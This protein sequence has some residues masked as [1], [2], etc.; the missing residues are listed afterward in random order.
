[1]SKGHGSQCFGAYIDE[2]SFFWFVV[3]LLRFIIVD[4]PSEE[5]NNFVTMCRKQGL[6][7]IPLV[8]P[9]TANGKCCTYP[10]DLLITSLIAALFLIWQNGFR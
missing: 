6:T 9:T 5:A 1:M 10:K 4:L 7:Y 2:R 3:T 8:T